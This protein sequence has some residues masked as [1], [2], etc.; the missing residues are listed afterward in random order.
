MCRYRKTQQSS[1][2]AWTGL[3]WMRIE[4]SGEFCDIKVA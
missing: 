2:A 3:N 1:A 4:S